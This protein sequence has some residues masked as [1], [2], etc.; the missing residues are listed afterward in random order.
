MLPPAFQS[1][2]S[3]YFGEVF[4]L[5]LH[6]TPSPPSPKTKSALSIYSLSTVPTLPTSNGTTTHPPTNLTSTHTLPLT[7]NLA[8]LPSPMP[9]C[10]E[11]R[12]STLGNPKKSKGVWLFLCVCVPPRPRTYPQA[13]RPCSR[14]RCSQTFPRP[15]RQS[16]QILLHSCPNQSF[17]NYTCVRTLLD[18][19]GCSRQC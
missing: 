16:I 11:F 17:E 18:R 3:C 5:S 13:R 12:T 2:G 19:S 15:Q 7:C 14:Y 8:K 4:R 6:P 1:G 9:A 10:L